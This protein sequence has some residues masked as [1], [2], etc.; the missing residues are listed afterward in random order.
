M[1]YGQLTTK[2]QINT[3][4]GGISA[5][6][7]NF[8]P[9]GAET[10]CSSIYLCAPSDSH[11]PIHGKESYVDYRRNVIE[12]QYDERFNLKPSARMSYGPGRN[13]CTVFIEGYR[14]RA[15]TEAITI[16]SRLKIQDPTT[17]P[18]LSP[19]KL[20]LEIRLHVYKDSR[21]FASKYV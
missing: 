15:N 18:I 6:G 11:N 2:Q 19:F 13:P 21:H 10:S 14:E 17:L 1:N 16:P 3:F 4:Y 8:I 12:M 9:S 7:R 20:Y 5:N